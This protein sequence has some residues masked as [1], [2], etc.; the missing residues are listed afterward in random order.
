M[1]DFENLTGRE[2]DVVLRLL[3]DEMDDAAEH[4]DDEVVKEIAAIIRKLG[5]GQ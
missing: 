4:N 1:N 3:E 5:G 2:H